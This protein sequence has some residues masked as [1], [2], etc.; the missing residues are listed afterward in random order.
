MTIKELKK[1]LKEYD[2]DTQIK[3]WGMAEDDYWDYYYTER[4]MK[5]TNIMQSHYDWKTTIIFTF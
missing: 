2:E 1:I 3:I 4:D 5:L